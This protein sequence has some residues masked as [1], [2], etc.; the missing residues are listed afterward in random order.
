MEYSI[1]ICIVNFN[2]SEF[3]LNTIYCLDRIT[4]NS[5]K[6]IIRDNN[7]RLQ[8]FLNLKKKVKARPNVELYRVENFNHIGGIAHGLAINDLLKKINSK[9]G[10]ILDADCTFL[11]KNW[12]EILINEINDEYPI[13]GT[14]APSLS[15]KPQD[16]PLMFAILFDAKI[17]KQLNIDF[18]PKNLEEFQDTGY[19]LRKKFMA[20][21]YR[22]KLLIDK[23]TRVY[24]SGPF[25]SVICAEYYFKSYIHIFASHFG[26]GSSLG[27]SK[28]LHTNRRNLYQ[29]P[30]IGPY[31]LKR[32]GKKEKEI[33][34]S[35]CKDIV[36]A[37]T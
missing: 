37:Q 34:I 7:S 15:Q 17:M 29:I 25:K 8:D 23:N 5:Y 9:Y 6:V 27:M 30:V 11:I 33:W 21:G 35:I 4:K 22:S 1:T 2:S 18:M 3:V 14:Q 19:E 24:K 12:D 13:I 31:L 36:K 10:V 32:K 26:R 16:F 28:Y 20:K